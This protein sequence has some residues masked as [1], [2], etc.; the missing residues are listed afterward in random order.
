MI[1]VVVLSSHVIGLSVI[2]SL[3]IMN[4]PIYLIY[5]EKRDMGYVSKYIREKVFAPHPAHSEQ[6]FIELLVHTA[7]K[8]GKSLLIPADDFTLVAVSKN[9][10]ILEKYF[11]TSFP[12][13]SITKKI[14]DKK[15]TYEL[16]KLHGINA[17][18]TIVPKS[19]HDLEE[20]NKIIE[21]PC[22]VKPSQSH[23]FYDVYGTKMFKVDNY[24]QLRS[25]YLDANSH[26]LEVMLQELIPGD[27]YAG[28]NYNTYIIESEPL[29]EFTAQ[30]NRL[31]P[32]GFGVPRVLVSKNIPEIIEPGRKI[33]SV[34]DY[35]GYACVE[36]KKDSRNGT[37]KLMEVNGR[38]NRSSLLSVK[39][40]INFSWIMY[41]H[42]IYGDLIKNDAYE[43]GIYWINLTED[44]IRSFQ[45]YRREKYNLQQ[46]IK[47]Y[48]SKHIYA[49]FDWKDLKPFFKRWTNLF[50]RSLTMIFVII[51][52]LIKKGACKLSKPFGLI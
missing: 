15:Y 5:Y 32:T 7:Q 26:G 27:D 47:P 30:K 43:E 18:E 41:R 33:L 28:I 20:Y 21:Y 42:L 37:Y 4:V 8:I 9:K 14:I 31:S 12:D 51:K 25:A 40:G 19:V 11:I 35:S 22:L 3:G 10:S 46:Y 16:A 36:F 45:Y 1:P 17:P 39:C 23:S 44:V 2:R 49:I 13:W 50:E 6:E 48:L 38:L 52:K 34:L 24:E 29:V